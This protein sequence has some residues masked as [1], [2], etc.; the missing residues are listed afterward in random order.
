[1]CRS[2]LQLRI[3]NTGLKRTHTK[4]RI[5]I[6]SHLRAKQESGWFDWL[7]HAVSGYLWCRDWSMKW[8][9][10]SSEDSRWTPWR[11]THPSTNERRQKRSEWWAER[12]TDYDVWTWLSVTHMDFGCRGKAVTDGLLGQTEINTHMHTHIWSVHNPVLI[13]D[14]TN[15]RAG[16]NKDEDTCPSFYYSTNNSF[17]C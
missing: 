15:R 10:G 4:N 7:F 17:K 8:H 13:L 12:S 5:N 11:S 2:P 14:V 16:N 6:L 3:S 1:M 9:S